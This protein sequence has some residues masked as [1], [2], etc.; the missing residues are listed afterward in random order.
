VQFGSLDSS[1][2]GW[3]WGCASPALRCAEGTGIPSKL[4]TYMILHQNRKLEFAMR[5]Y[6]TGFVI[7]IKME[8]K[9]WRT[10]AEAR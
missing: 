4:T 5:P 9:D 2:V 1:K 10:T 6:P 3:H 8:A 7:P